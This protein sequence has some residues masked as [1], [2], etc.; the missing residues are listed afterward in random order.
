[1]VF[2]HVST[3]AYAQKQVLFELCIVILTVPLD[4]MHPVSYEISLIG[5]W[6]HQ[7][8]WH[9]Q[10]SFQQVNDFPIDFSLNQ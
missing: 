10:K 3:G 6:M 8:Q 1:M 2:G 7:I 4:L 5:N 9:C